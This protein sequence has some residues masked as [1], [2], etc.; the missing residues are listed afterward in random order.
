MVSKLVWV[1][2]VGGICMSLSVCAEQGPPV[3]K[4]LGTIDCDMVETTPVVLHGK[5]YRFEYVRDNYKANTTGKSYFRFV[6]VASGEPTAPFARGY[7]LGSAFVDGDAAYVYGVNTWAGPHIHVFWSK[8]L[9]EW[10]DQ[11]AMEL[12]GWEIF[13]TSVCKGRDAYVMAFEIG[14]P[15]EET[16]NGFTMRFASS[17]DLRNWSLTPK[18]CVYTKERYSACPALRFLDDRYYMVYLEAYPGPSYAPHIVRS[19]DLITWEGS[20]FKPIMKHSDEDKKVANPNL[21]EAQRKRIADAV[22]INNSDVDFCEFQEKTIINYSW[23]NQQ[24]IEHLAE[25]VYDGSEAQFLK[26]FFPEK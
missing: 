22:N 12:P 2:L 24:G 25:A 14:A 18:E 9:R 13:N 4:K 1:I 8:D 16:G 7:H 3:I 20:P 21:T 10:K 6:D 23:G 15:K 11:P 17:K 26:S 5:L 19:K